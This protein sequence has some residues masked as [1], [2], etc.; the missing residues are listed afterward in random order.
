LKYSFYSGISGKIS[1][2]VLVGF[3]CVI[4]PINLFIYKKLEKL[5]VN[6]EYQNLNAEAAKLQS[7][8]NLDPLSIPLAPPEMSIHVQLFNS[9]GLQSIFESPGFPVL[10]EDLY[11]LETV[12]LDTVNIITKRIPTGNASEELL[13]TVSKSKN[14]MNEQLS[15]F[16][17]YL[18]YLTGAVIIVMVILVFSISE[19]I[20][21]PLKN[22]IT[23]AENIN[24]S[25]SMERLP[26]PT[27]QDETKL[28]CVT[29]NNM[30]SRIEE[31]IN[32]QLH[33]F[34]SATHELKTPLTIMNTQLT[35]AI[36]NSTDVLTTNTLQSMLEEV[37]RL[38]RI[39]SDFLLLSQVKTKEFKLRKEVCDLEEVLFSALTKIKKIADTKNIQ[40]HVT[41]ND[42]S[43]QVT[44]DK[45]KIQTVFLNLLENAA[46]YALKDSV[47]EIQLEKKYDATS[48]SIK[49]KIEMPIKDID[50]LGKARYMNST[51]ARGMGL[52][53]WICNQIIS[54]HNGE[55]EI[56]ADK[57]EFT[58][59]T[60]LSNKS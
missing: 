42:A 11:Q 23:I 15:G 43:L 35:L 41:Q 20:L 40:F 33:F 1:I 32:T 6:A 55:L 17:V 51:S 2:I 45:D 39:I 19:L 30:L 54:M 18:F 37:G 21:R 26:V 7:K 27:A 24:T 60:R 13:L 9:Q 48:V 10:Q 38:E 12:E 53:L 16:R 52:G 4:L 59:T 29:L 8:I 46:H 56:N 58:V 49:N 50:S 5:I 44:I 28:L 34:D 57:L 3:L 22:V 14:K 25:E 36:T 31:S 47:I